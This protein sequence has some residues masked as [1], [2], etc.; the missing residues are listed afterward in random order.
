M[1]I[2][3]R[4][5]RCG[6]SPTEAISVGRPKYINVDTEAR[7]EF[8]LTTSRTPAEAAKSPAITTPRGNTDARKECQYLAFGVVLTLAERFQPN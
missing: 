8:S 1:L 3:R 2:E 7:R 4:L 5:A 6:L